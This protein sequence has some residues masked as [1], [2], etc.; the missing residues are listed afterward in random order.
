VPYLKGLFPDTVIA[1]I[2]KH[3]S[4]KRYL[5]FSRPEYFASLSEDSKRSLA[6]QGGI[7]DEAEAKAFLLEPGAEDAVKVRVWDDLAKKPG[8]STP[9]LEH[10]L[11]YANRVALSHKKHTL[12]MNVQ[13]LKRLEGT[14]F[15]DGKGIYPPR[16]PEFSYKETLTITP[17]A[18]PIVWE[19]KS[20]TKHAESGKPMHSEIGFLRAPP[21]G[22]VELTLT[23]PF[24]LLEMSV[25][26]QLSESEVVMVAGTDSLFRV[27]SAS[28][29]ATL[30]LRRS[31]Q[32]SSDGRTLTFN[33][34]MATDSSPELKHHLLCN[35]TKQ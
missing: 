29:P 22:S 23:H 3:V 2:Q 17:T 6:L 27:P 11:Q 7:F 19:F 16:V 21:D 1:A 33:M 26:N 12:G 25:G 35:L 5:C 15:G 13:L 24:G 28:R 31:Y 14:W 8:L 32:L 30:G 18:K 9:D 4:A 20:V 34:D 10:F